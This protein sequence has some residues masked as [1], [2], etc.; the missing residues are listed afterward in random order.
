V[1]AGEVTR[2]RIALVEDHESVAIGLAAMLAA[3]PDLELV[4]TARTVAELLDAVGPSP[5]LDLCVLDLR[6]ADSSLPEDNVRALRERGVRRFRIE[7]VRERASDVERLVGGYRALIAGRASAKETLRELRG[8]RG[9]GGG[10][11]G[12]RASENRDGGRW[13]GAGGCLLRRLVLAVRGQRL[14]G[15]GKRGVERRPRGARASLD[16]RTVG[17]ASCCPL[18]RPAAE[19]P[20]RLL[21]GGRLAV[22]CQTVRAVGLGG[23]RLRPAP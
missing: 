21:H 8:E 13:E 3:E 20:A 6:L 5:D 9:G 15:V 18:R 22:G 23:R 1:N 12:E 2:R 16:L 11:G 10:D 4:H 14:G 7:L 17:V 19:T